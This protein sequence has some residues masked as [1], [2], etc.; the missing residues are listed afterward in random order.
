M[1][2]SSTGTEEMFEDTANEE[3]KEEIFGYNLDD[4]IDFDLE[5]KKNFLESVR[6]ASVDPIN[7]KA[8]MIK[9]LDYPEKDYASI[10]NPETGTNF[11]VDKSEAIIN[12]QK[13]LSEPDRL[14]EMFNLSP[15]IN[16]SGIK[17]FLA[18]REETPYQR[19]AL[20]KSAL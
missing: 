16:R 15:K 6:R 8:I 17:R 11:T 1:Q 4:C 10:E 14:K 12:R 7:L 20:S 13:K 2:D 19:K 5:E 18:A 3:T 9:H